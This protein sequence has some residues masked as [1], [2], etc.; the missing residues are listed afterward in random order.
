[1]TG[2]SPLVDTQTVRQQTVASSELLDSLPTST[3]HLNTLVTL[4]PGFTG[5]SA[6]TGAY[7]A[8]IG[9]VGVTGA[10]TFHGKAGTRVS[11]PSTRHGL[12]RQQSAGA[13][14]RK[15]SASNSQASRGAV[16]AGWPFLARLFAECNGI[17][18]SWLQSSHDHHP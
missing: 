15:R 17:A 8:R 2:A 16:A 11:W 18:K 5:L 9:S 14:S 4:T 12:N 13:N 7:S 1:V 3:K 6:V 10:G